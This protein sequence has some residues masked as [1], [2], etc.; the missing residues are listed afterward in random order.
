MKL[1]MIT[2]FIVHIIIKELHVVR[3]ECIR[4]ILHL[5]FFKCFLYLFLSLWHL[6][7]CILYKVTWLHWKW[8]C[9]RFMHSLEMFSLSVPLTWWTSTCSTTRL[10]WWRGRR[11]RRFTRGRGRKR[12]ASCWTGETICWKHIHSEEMH[13]NHIKCSWITA[14]RSYL[15]THAFASC[16]M[17]GQS[18]FNGQSLL[19]HHLPDLQ[20][21]WRLKRPFWLLTLRIFTGF[22]VS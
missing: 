8:A 9:D 20:P 13:A 4:N 2:W 16:P 3:Y 15:S 10:T 12:W 21:R 11:V 22:S 18:G 5:W 17:R 7:S 14:P 19:G 1:E 6:H